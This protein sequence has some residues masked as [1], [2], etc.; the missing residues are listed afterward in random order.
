MDATPLNELPDD[1]ASLKE[2]IRAQRAAL[3]ERE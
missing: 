1:A 2:M 3:T